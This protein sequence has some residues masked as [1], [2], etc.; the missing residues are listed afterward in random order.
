MS[1]EHSPKLGV[2]VNKSKAYKTFCEPLPA[3]PEDSF[4]FRYPNIGN[5]VKTYRKKGILTKI[6]EWLTIFNNQ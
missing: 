6:L 1:K 2:I 3:F 4:V 5:G